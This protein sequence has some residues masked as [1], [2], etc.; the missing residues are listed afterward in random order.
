MSEMDLSGVTDVALQ[1][2]IDDLDTSQTQLRSF[3]QA[4][5]DRREHDPSRHA[6]TTEDDS[7]GPLTGKIKDKDGEG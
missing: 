2:M 5:L 6:M 4:E 1:M 7:A 3:Y